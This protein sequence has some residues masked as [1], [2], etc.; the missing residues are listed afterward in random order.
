MRLSPEFCFFCKTTSTFIATRLGCDEV[1]GKRMVEDCASYASNVREEVADII[2]EIIGD[3][4]QDL[5]MLLDLVLRQR[6][7]LF[8]ENAPLDFEKRR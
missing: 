5:S 3:D 8:N 2:L 1:T 7:L 4:S 6:M